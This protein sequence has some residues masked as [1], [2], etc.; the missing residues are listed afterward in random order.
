[1]ASNPSERQ[2]KQKLLAKKLEKLSMT[3]KE[4]S[5]VSISGTSNVIRKK[6]TTPVW[7]EV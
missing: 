7:H 1:M 6:T 2:L 5:A 3:D 4:E